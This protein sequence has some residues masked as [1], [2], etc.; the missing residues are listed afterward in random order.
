MKTLDR[1]IPVT[2]SAADPVQIPEEA[3]VAEAAQGSASASPGSVIALSSGGLTINLIFDAAAMA[4]PAS[5]RAG[6]QQAAALLSTAIS[7]KITIN[8]KIDYSGTGGGAAAGPDHGQWVSY[9][10]VRSYLVNNAT[11]GDGTFDALPGSSTLQGQ[12]DVAV[13]NSQLKLW[14]LLGANDTS[15]DDGSATFATDIAPSVLVGVALHELT[16]AMGR[17]PYGTQPDVFDFFRF[18][19]AG[20]RLFLNGGTAPAAYF[21][22]DGGNTKLADYG[23]SSDASDFLNSGAQGANDPFNEFYTGS[24]FQQLTTFDLKQ[25]VA[26]GYHLVSAT[27]VV[28]ESFGA[29]SLVQIGSGYFVN[30]VSGGTGPELKLGGAAIAAGQLGPWVP[31]GAEATTSGYEVVWKVAGADEYTAWNFDASGN[32]VSS[33][34]GYVSGTSAALESLEPILHQDLNGDGTIGL[35]GTT[36]EAFGSTSLVQVGTGY[37]LNPAS[38]GPE[39]KLGG[40]AIA[41]GQLGP[42][43]PIG[44]EA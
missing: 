40:A 25:L 31:I 32:F 8:L 6:I 42:W 4:A 2:N 44:A 5:F 18:T 34:I 22:L 20:T 15:T 12:S 16:H 7:D 13:W 28:I 21:S 39:L 11:A 38:G 30:P 10:N 1:S 29:T 3:L 37:D 26:L 43:V 17:V 33:A 24:T 27:P 23:Q 36:I 9:S 14:G 41:A 35:V 19:G